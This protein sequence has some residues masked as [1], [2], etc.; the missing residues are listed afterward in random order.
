MSTCEKRH[1]KRHKNDCPLFFVSDFRFLHTLPT[2][3]GKKADIYQNRRFAFGFVFYRFCAAFLSK[4]FVYYQCKTV[5]CAVCCTVC[6]KKTSPNAKKP[7]YGFRLFLV[8]YTVECWI[9]VSVAGLCYTVLA[10]IGFTPSL[11]QQ[12]L[13]MMNTC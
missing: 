9:S 4:Y 2:G 8:I 11:V 13:Y 6:S 12:N 10:R 5:L 3:K 7:S 1:K